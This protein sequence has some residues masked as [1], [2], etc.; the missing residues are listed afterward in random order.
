MVWLRLIFLLIY[1]FLILFGCCLVFVVIVDGGFKTVKKDSRFFSRIPIIN[2][3]I[4]KNS[5]IYDE[6]K[7]NDNQVG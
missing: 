2:N 3:F 6:S 5:R 4:D 7:H 1:F